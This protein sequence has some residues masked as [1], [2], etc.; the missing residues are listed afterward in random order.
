MKPLQKLA[1][2]AADFCLVL[3][4]IVIA[5]GLRKDFDWNDMVPQFLWSP[6]QLAFVL[7]LAAATV[8]SFFY[9]GLYKKLW[10]YAGTHEL[11]G[12]IKACLWSFLPF[13]AIAMIYQGQLFPRSA[14]A[15]TLLVTVNICGGIRLLL[16]LASETM[17]KPIT[18]TRVIIVGANDAG[19][20]VVRDR[21]RKYVP[22][23]FVDDRPDRA[24]VRIH[25]IPVQGR[26]EDLPRLVDSQLVTE[27]VLAAPPAAEVRRVMD[28]L[29]GREVQ[30]RVVPAMQ[31][32]VAG[33]VELARLR[34]LSIED[35]LE[36]EP[37]KVAP[38]L[39]RPLLA[40]KRVLITGA[41]GSI[42]SEIARQ[43]A[44]F[45]PEKLLLV[46]RGE[47]SLYEIGLELPQATLLVCDVCRERILERIFEEHRPHFVF[48]AAAHKHVPLMEAAPAEAVYTNVFGTRSVLAA[49]QKYGVE[50]FIL[51]STDKAVNPNNVMGATKRLAEKLV[52][53][54]GHPGYAAVR[55]GN[56]LGSR[57]S[58]VP[59]M[60]KQILQGGPVTVTDPAMTRYFMTIPEAVTLVL[61]ASGL[62]Q[63]GEIYLLD[64]GK[65][66]RILDLAQNLIRL[67]GFEPDKD[68]AIKITGCRPGEKLEEQLVGKDESTE[69]TRLAKISK[70]I[71]R[72]P[73]PE[74]P[75][76]LLEELRQHCLNGDQRQCRA[77]L[78]KLLEQAEAQGESSPRSEAS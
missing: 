76:E 14:L 41:G 59:T 29:A 63:G 77:L 19:E 65:P 66:V 35:L 78:L 28:L 67:C 57:G 68:I 64:M 58:V 39:V 10:R 12:V 18:S 42:G 56:V 36:R 31:D 20:A 11:V 61:Q 37:I 1:L 26:L 43:V 32:L 44:S 13:Q 30:L 8:L 27:V 6:A 50:R 9:N 60:Q 24:G 54:L 69:P 45:G 7:G 5:L 23:G 22:V 21:S 25:G 52:A 74:W 49:C 51:L 3:A 33:K 70:V 75:G 55:F 71:T 15:L 34:Q 53:Q 38:E 4:A 47:N 62:A 73:G 16:R 46:G 2:A 48:H 40:G 17:G 72:V